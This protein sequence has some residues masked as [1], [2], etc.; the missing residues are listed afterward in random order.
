M[1]LLS[2]FKELSKVSKHWQSS[3]VY[4]NVDGGLGPAVKPASRPSASQTSQGGRLLLCN[5]AV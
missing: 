1:V 5:V 3:D 4:L 2:N